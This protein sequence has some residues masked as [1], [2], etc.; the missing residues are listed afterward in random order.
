[1]HEK[2]ILVY[3]TEAAIFRI[4]LPKSRTYPLY[5]S[6]TNTNILEPERR[7]FY[8]YILNIDKEEM[9]AT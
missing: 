7:I 1:M 3:A 2:K 6:L 4:R 8:I 9:L 5:Y